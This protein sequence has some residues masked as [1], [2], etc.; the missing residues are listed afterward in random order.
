MEKT[1]FVIYCTRLG[2][3]RQIRRKKRPIFRPKCEENK[4]T[5]LSLNGKMCYAELN[6]PIG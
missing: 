5:P 1:D 2:A 4:E 6:Y 3:I